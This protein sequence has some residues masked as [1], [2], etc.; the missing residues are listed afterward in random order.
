M[1]DTYDEVDAMT[2]PGHNADDD[3]GAADHKKRRNNGKTAPQK[4]EGRKLTKRNALGEDMSDLVQ[5]SGVRSLVPADEPA[6][7]KLSDS[8]DEDTSDMA[9]DDIIPPPAEANEYDDTY[10]PP[11]KSM[12]KWKTRTVMTMITKTGWT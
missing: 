6:G 1:A 11:L 7:A 12:R 2:I 10:L 4:I 9:E 5:E 3:A 8:V